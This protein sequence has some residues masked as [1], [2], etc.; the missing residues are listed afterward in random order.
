ML[1]CTEKSFISFLA[2]QSNSVCVGFDDQYKSDRDDFNDINVYFN[3]W[4]IDGLQI[5]MF[6]KCQNVQQPEGSFL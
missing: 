6:D 4:W 5:T 2:V 1:I 3:L